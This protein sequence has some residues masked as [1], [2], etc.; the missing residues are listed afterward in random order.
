MELAVA[1]GVLAS[2]GYLGIGLERVAQ[3]V[4]EAQHRTRGDVYP[5]RTSSSASL[6]DDFDVQRSLDIGLPLV[7]GLTSSSR[8]S[9]GPGWLSVIGLSPPPCAR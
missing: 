3:E 8:V 5:R 6:A 2:F 4:Q 9:K 1:V 7:S